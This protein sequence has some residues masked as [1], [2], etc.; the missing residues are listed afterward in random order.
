M[1]K[2]I[3]FSTGEFKVEKTSA[4]LISF[5]KFSEQISAFEPLKAVQIKMKEIRYTVQQKLITLICSIVIGCA[6]TSDVNDKLVPETIAPRMLNMLR[7]P[8]QSQLNIILKKFSEGNIQQL[9]EVHHQL[10]QENSQSLSTSETVV[11]DVDQTG[12]LANGKK[13]ECATKGYFP[14]KRGKQ[15]YQLSAAFCGSTG[16]TVTMYLDP[17]NTNS[18]KRLKDMLDDISVKYSKT[19]TNNSLILRADS[20]YGSDDS[21]EIFKATKAKFVVKGYSSQRAKNLA[22]NVKRDDW[23]EIDKYVDVCELPC[24]CDLRIILVRVLEKDGVKHTYLVTNIPNSDMSAKD[25]FH[26]YNGRQTIEAFIKT[27]KKTYG[28]K[29]LRTKCFLGIYG[30]LWL[31]FITHNLISWM[32]ATVFAETEFGELGVDTIVRKFGS[33]SAEVTET[34]NHIDIKLPS[35]SNLARLF[36]HS[37]NPKYIQLEIP[38]SP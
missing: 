15:G 19:I 26:F 11:V 21:V 30:F 35:L 17:G 31:V 28:I 20:G 3:T 22:A 5:I 27:C 10:F 24:Q 2:S 6:F 13:F 38:L 37:L 32:K 7:F 16:E 36:V 29:N 9:K 33:I 8:D 34:H 1:K 12:L 23:E 14:R 25:L 4:W 18:Y